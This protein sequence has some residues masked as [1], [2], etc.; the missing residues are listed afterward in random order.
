MDIVAAPAASE[1]GERIFRRTVLGAHHAAGGGCEVPLDP[2]V[3]YLL[4]DTV[5]VGCAILA[6]VE[7]VGFAHG[8]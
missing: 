5:V 8:V 7:G 3:T 1:T 2:V 6:I 4:L